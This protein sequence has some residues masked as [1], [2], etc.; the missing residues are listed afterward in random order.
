[1]S[2]NEGL[3]HAHL[4]NTLHS[5]HVMRHYFTMLLTQ[6]RL[7]RAKCARTL[8]P[9][10]LSD[11]KVGRAIKHLKDDLSD[12]WYPDPLRWSDILRKDFLKAQLLPKG[13][14]RAVKHEAEMKNVLDLPKQNGTLRYSLE[15]SLVDRFVYQLIASELGLQLDR[16]I[17]NHVFSF[18]VNSQHSGG[19]SHKR[20]FKQGTNQW[21]H[22]ERCAAK[23]S[24]NLYVV[25]ADVQTYYDSISAD[26]V[27][28]SIQDAIDSAGLGE[29]EQVRLHRLTSILHK[30]LSRW[31][32]QD[33]RGLP[34]NR[35][36]SSFLANMVMRKVDDEMIDSGYDYFRYMDDIRIRCKTH[37][38]ARKAMALLCTKLRLIGLS[39]NSKKTAIREPEST[40]HKEQAKPPDPRVRDIDNMWKAGS[41]QLKAA[42]IPYLQSLTAETIRRGDVDSSTFR[43]CVTR[44]ERIKLCPDVHF[45]LDGSEELCSVAI[46]SIAQNGHMIDYICRL[47]Y[48]L[49]PTLANIEA[50]EILLL[51]GDE[52]LYYWQRHRLTQL[53]LYLHSESGNYRCSDRLIREARKSGL[54]GECLFVPRELAF[55][56]LGCAGESRDREKIADIFQDGLESHQEQRAALIAMHELDYDRFVADKVPKRI[57]P[58]LRGALGAHKKY[59]PGQYILLPRSITLN[60]FNNNTK[61][62]NEYAG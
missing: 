41:L 31:T 3:T 13:E 56:I 6:H 10:D 46:E 40:W 14:G 54:K 20:L 34:Q 1:M 39:L 59:S 47:I 45:S 35:D 42:A 48:A 43:F 62:T 32:F 2:N 18:R 50:V 53:L 57:R 12:D 11:Q 36:A 8:E 15:Q 16:T 55:I 28:A 7:R 21:S 24:K 23:K 19:K 60:E 29:K 51:D 9:E 61:N 33:G 22:F 25:E 4:W 58:H 49:N 30:L 37:S 26:S 52:H 38:D 27:R 17:S 44:L 5:K